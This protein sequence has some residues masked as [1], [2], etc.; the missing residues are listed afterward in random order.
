MHK[1]KKNQTKAKPSHVTFKLTTRS[2]FRFSRQTMQ[3]QNNQNSIYKLIL[4]MKN[5]IMTLNSAHFTDDLHKDHHQISR[6]NFTA[7][8]PEIKLP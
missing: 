3:Y 8:P 7:M 6:R 4:Q 5:T 1:N 2:I